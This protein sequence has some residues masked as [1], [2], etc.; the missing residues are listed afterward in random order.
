[1][2]DSIIMVYRGLRLED[3]PVENSF[4]ELRMNIHLFGPI[5]EYW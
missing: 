5:N 3:K 4:L 1:M 2:D